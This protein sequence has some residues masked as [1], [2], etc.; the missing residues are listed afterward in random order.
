VHAPAVIAYTAAFLAVWAT[1]TLALSQCRWFQRRAALADRLRP[2]TSH[3]EPSVAD[4]V[5]AWLN[6]Q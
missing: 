6:H 3:P 4:E 2:Y 5:E 1:A